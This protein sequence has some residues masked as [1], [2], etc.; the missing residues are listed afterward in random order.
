[1][2]G[3]KG[4]LRC[5]Q[6]ANLIKGHEQLRASEAAKWYKNEIKSYEKRPATTTNFCLQWQ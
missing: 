1:M 4:S 3:E 5:G 6:K 2:G